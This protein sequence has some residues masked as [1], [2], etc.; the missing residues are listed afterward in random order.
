MFHSFLD[1]SSSAHAWDAF[2]FAHAS[3]RLYCV[4]N[5]QALPASSHKAS[6]KLGPRLLGDPATIDVPP[7]EVDAGEDEEGSLGIL[8][9]IKIYDDDVG[10][11]FLVCGEACTLVR[12]KTY[13]FSC[14][15]APAIHVCICLVVA[16]I[17]ASGLT[18]LFYFFR[19][20]AY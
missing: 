18:F 11:R 8:P 7:P 10:I 14:V 5:N 20:H 12:R 6:G 16:Y 1:C 15:C 2:Q 4:R 19:I 13:L 3:F 9:A 17:I